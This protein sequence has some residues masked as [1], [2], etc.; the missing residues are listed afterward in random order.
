MGQIS[1]PPLQLIGRRSGSSNDPVGGL[2]AKPCGR[3]LVLPDL[4]QECHLFS[5]LCEV[6]DEFLLGFRCYMFGF[7]DSLDGEG[8]AEGLKGEFV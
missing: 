6:L 1:A 7:E 2:L 3:F 4:C 5:E 8:Q